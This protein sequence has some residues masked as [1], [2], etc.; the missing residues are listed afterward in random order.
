MARRYFKPNVKMQPM[1]KLRLAI[2]GCDP[3]FAETD[4]VMRVLGFLCSMN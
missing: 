2:E 4:L 3:T 1:R